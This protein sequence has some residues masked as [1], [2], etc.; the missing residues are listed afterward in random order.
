M[1]E[2]EY[3]EQIAPALAEIAKKIAA[4]GGSMVAC[5]EWQK[6]DAG[7]TVIGVSEESGVGQQ[8]TRLAALCKG[9][10]DQLCIE[11]MRRFD[12]S[13]TMFGQLISGNGQVH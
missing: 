2:Q 13:R 9:N 12:M 3:D 11:V 10:F 1:T 7:I 8:I 4:L 5:V 6:N